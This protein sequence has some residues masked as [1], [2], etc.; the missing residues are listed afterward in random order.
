[1]PTVNVKNGILPN[2]NG[3]G[4]FTVTPNPA[5][6]PF[7]NALYPDPQEILP[8]ALNPAAES[9]T[10][11]FFSAPNRII[12]QD[13]FM[14]RVDHQLTNGTTIFGRYSFDDDVKSVP[15]EQGNF[16]DNDQARRQY[17]TFQANTV[18]SPTIVNSARVALNRTSQIAD[19]SP[20]NSALESL[21]WVDGQPMG[22]MG[23]GQ[24]NGILL[25]DDS[26][27]TG[28]R[29][30]QWTYNL[31]EYG[32]D[33]TYV[34][35]THTMKWGGV[36]R[37]VQ[38]NNNVQTDVKASYI[39]SGPENML[40]AQPTEWAGTLPGDSG[41]KGLRNTMYGF[42][43]QD[44]YS[45]SSRLTLNLGLRWE[46]ISDPTESN[47]LISNLLSIED[48]PNQL[49]I[50][51]DHRDRFPDNIGQ[52]LFA[53][54][55][56]SKKNIQPRFGFALQLD[57]SATRVLRGGAGIYHDLVLPAYYTQSLSKAAPFYSRARIRDDDVLAA[58]FPFT[59]RIVTGPDVRLR[60]EPLLPFIKQPTKYSYNLA[61]QQQI[62]ERG[63][64]EIAYVGSQ[65]RYLQR[66]FQ[67][68][69]PIPE[70]LEGGIVYHP[71]RSGGSEAC[72]PAPFGGWNGNAGDLPRR[73]DSTSVSGIR[74]NSEWDRVRQR[75]GDANS[76]YNGLQ[77]RFSRQTTAGSIVTANYTFSKVMNQ[78]GGLNMN[79]NGTRDPNTSQD[80]ADRTRDYGPAAFNSTHVLTSTGTVPLPFQFDSGAANAILGG[81]TTS[82]VFTALSGQPFTPNMGFD[83]SRIGNSGAS[84]RPDINPNF[85][86]NPFNPTSGS[87][88]RGPVGTADQWY[89]PTAFVLPNPLGLATPQPG[90]M[91]NVGRNTIIGPRLISL[92][93]TLTKRFQ[94]GEAKDL[95]FRAEFFNMLNRTNL[96]VPDNEP[97]DPD[98][99]D[100]GISRALPN[101]G[102]IP[103]DET[104]TTARQIQF[105]L[106]FTF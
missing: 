12:R 72:L 38:N 34:R 82:A 7:I 69:D 33:M 16:L 46:W 94:L 75:G 6:V 5:V 2:A 32:D 73:C 98:A 19:Q 63:V 58:S 48:N 77:V 89:D 86:G 106:K 9:T 3:F 52:D 36:I 81:W 41:Y 54:T 85:T 22:D 101:S 92:D 26:G 88:A 90:F 97:L 11:L 30:R 43:F 103:A 39:F 14:G 51:P 4:T 78:Q 45:V 100:D 55:E 61:L 31:W 15:D 84:D 50:H 40:L 64:I 105:G 87:N 56:M 10:G 79:D 23:V 13:Y 74:R 53:Y 99:A 93:F 60:Q 47:N 44:D 17:I 70:L 1:M 18:V 24:A 27:G 35:G 67:L 95:T 91:G 8:H 49:A 80:P 28:T 62:G 96:G 21:T 65:S 83:W 59:S 57:D 42:Y 37:R 76:N 20:L 66:Y 71:S 25:Y 29:P 68:N 104:T 102:R